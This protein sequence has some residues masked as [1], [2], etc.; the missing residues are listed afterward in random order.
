MIVNKSAKIEINIEINDDQFLFHQLEF[1]YSKPLVVISVS[2]S[3][4]FIVISWFPL[5]NS[6][7]IKESDEFLKVKRNF[8]FKETSLFKVSLSVHQYPTSLNSSQS[9]SK[10]EI[11]K[12]FFSIFEVQTLTT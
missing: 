3:T 9:F 4:Y 7:F 2:V 5:N 12:L 8:L 11:L 1:L 10:E 6:S